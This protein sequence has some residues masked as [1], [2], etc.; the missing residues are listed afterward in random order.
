M[1]DLTRLQ[2]KRKLKEAQRVYNRLLSVEEK[3]VTQDSD[4][5]ERETWV[6]RAR[7]WADVKNLYGREYFTAKQTN[8]EDT[9]LFHTRYIPW[10]T[11]AHRL[12]MDGEVYDIEAIDNIDYEN[13]RMQIRARQERRYSHEPAD[14]GE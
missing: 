9:V 6:E 5:I 1:S 12:S 4:G 11:V 14:S 7:I 10:L 3:S 8:S 13:R 2:R